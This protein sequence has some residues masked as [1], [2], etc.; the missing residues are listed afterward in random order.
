MRRS[1][2]T[3]TLVLI[4]NQKSFYEGRWFD[5][6]LYYIGMGSKGSQSLKGNQNITL[7]ESNTNGI[8]ATNKLQG[9]TDREWGKAI[10]MDKNI[11]LKID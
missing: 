4:T 10:E 2:R 11:A 7:Y 8:D 9:E 1:K 5:N 6:K 3:N